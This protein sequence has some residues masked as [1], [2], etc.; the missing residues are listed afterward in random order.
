[1]EDILISLWRL[2]C[3]CLIHGPPS[4]KKKKKKKGQLKINQP[5]SRKKML[6]SNQLYIT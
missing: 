3:L 6:N 4:K 5:Q 1:M 2:F